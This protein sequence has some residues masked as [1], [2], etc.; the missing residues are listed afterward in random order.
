MNDCPWKRR[1]TRVAGVRVLATWLLATHAWISPAYARVNIVGSTLLPHPLGSSQSDTRNCSDRLTLLSLSLSLS[2]FHFRK[3]TRA[4][5]RTRR[6]ASTRPATSARKRLQAHR[7]HRPG[8][9]SPT[10]SSTMCQPQTSKPATPG[11]FASVSREGQAAT[12]VARDSP[13][14]SENVTNSRAESLGRLLIV[15]AT[16]VS[17]DT[18]VPTSPLACA[19]FP[20][21]LIGQGSF[22]YFSLLGVCVLAK[23]IYFTFVSIWAID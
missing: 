7:R 20:L 11:E 23:C 6:A 14:E 4:R 10:P 13:R 8:T 15:L 3:Q 21:V 16:Y 9:S 5:W 19:N 2:C 17:G 12:D 22:F 1:D 18:S